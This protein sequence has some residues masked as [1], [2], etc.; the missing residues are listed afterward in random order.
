MFPYSAWS[1][2]I[3][4]ESANIGLG[5]GRWRTKPQG[6]VSSV[7]DRLL[8]ATN[9]RGSQLGLQYSGPYPLNAFLQTFLAPYVEAPEI[10]LPRKRHTPASYQSM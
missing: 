3:T 4:G 10:V 8:T 1:E 5:S 6:Y 7:S 2:S 9:P